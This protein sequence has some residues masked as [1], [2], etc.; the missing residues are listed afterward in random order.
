[1]SEKPTEI[2]YVD[3]TIYNEPPPGEASGMKKGEW[4]ELAIMHYHTAYILKSKFDLLEAE[5]QNLKNLLKMKIAGGGGGDLP[6]Q[7]TGGVGGEVPKD[8]I[9]LFSGGTGGESPSDQKIEDNPDFTQKGGAFMSGKPDSV[10]VSFEAYNEL[11]KEL[12]KVKAEL[13]KVKGRS[14]RKLSDRFTEILNK[15]TEEDIQRWIDFDANRMNGKT[16][17]RKLK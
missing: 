8:K 11:S 9:I 5:N 12:E 7:D 15:F 10:Y 3:E 16:N 17:N 2:I 4:R 13:E 14:N 1:M 6:L